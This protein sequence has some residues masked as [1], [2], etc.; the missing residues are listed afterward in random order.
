[1]AMSRCADPGGSS[2]AGE[3]DPGAA[4][5]TA[6]DIGASDP[7]RVGTARDRAGTAGTGVGTGTGTG[8]SD[9]STHALPHD[10]HRLAPLPS[11]AFD[12]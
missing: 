6:D 12:R 10:R 3:E 9:R 1:M 2:V 5:D 11:A 4:L 8:K 7:A